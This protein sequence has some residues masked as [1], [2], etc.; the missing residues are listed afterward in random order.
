VAAAV[1][2][3]AAVAGAAAPLE[4]AAVDA[5]AVVEEAGEVVNLSQSCGAAR[6][7]AAPLFY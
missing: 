3:A 5:P 2:P 7:G 1:H 6:I 4:V